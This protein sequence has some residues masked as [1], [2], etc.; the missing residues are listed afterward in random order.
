MSEEKHDVVKYVESIEDVQ[1]AA[2]NR[3]TEELSET[4]TKMESVSKDLETYKSMYRRIDDECTLLKEQIK[5]L[6]TIVNLL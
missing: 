2:I 1:N 3:L 4:K 5:A 6:K